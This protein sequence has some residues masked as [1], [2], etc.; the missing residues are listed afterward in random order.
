M[1]LILVLGTDLYFARILT[2][3]H[4]ANQHHTNLGMNMSKSVSGPAKTHI[5]TLDEKHAIPA[6]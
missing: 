5:H 2:L 6:I 4:T 3:P 1:I